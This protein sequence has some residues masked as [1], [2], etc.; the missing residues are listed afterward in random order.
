MQEA[1]LI[2]GW[3]SR[4]VASS[5]YRTAIFALPDDRCALLA[6]Q[7]Q[8]VSDRWAP[9]HEMKRSA[10]CRA[11]MQR[12]GSC[13]PRGYSDVAI[14]LV[15]ESSGFAHD[16]AWLRSC[17]SCW[18]VWGRITA[19]LF[20]GPCLPPSAC[21]PEIGDFWLHVGSKSVT[22]N[23][24]DGLKTRGCWPP[25]A[26]GQGDCRDLHPALSESLR[27][28]ACVASLSRRSQE[29]NPH[30]G[31]ARLSLARHSASR[32]RPDSNRGSAAD[33]LSA[34]RHNGGPRGHLLK[35]ATRLSA[36]RRAVCAAPLERRGSLRRPRARGAAPGRAALHR[37]DRAGDRSPPG[38]VARLPEH[39]AAELSAG[40]IRLHAFASQW[41]GIVT[42][43]AVIVLA[44]RQP[45]SPREP[46]QRSSIAASGQGGL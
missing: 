10:T 28:A 8:A 45:R 24:G 2:T 5:T 14:W 32:S 22:S 13:R 37:G 41:A 36:M 12:G 4:T 33:L 40:R 44:L 1:E 35:A 38:A 42:L 27:P 25:T 19:H 6:T 31:L 30:R 26:L 9:C 23:A 7:S 29:P 16:R 39:S 21:G 11:P 18:R 3:C 43:L 15:A 34:E 17:A 20:C 46:A